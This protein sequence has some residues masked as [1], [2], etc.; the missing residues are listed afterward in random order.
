MKLLIKTNRYFVGVSLLV[1]CV[2]GV[3]FYLLFQIIIDRDINNK[4]QNR[5]NYVAKQLNISDSLLFY[6]KYSANTLSIRPTNGLLTREE[7][8]DTVLYDEVEKKS[9]GYRQLTF[10]DNINGQNYKIHLRRALVETHELI[11]GVVLL[12]GILFLALVAILALLNSLVSKQLWSPFYVTLEK[13][14]TYKADSGI[15]LQ[16]SRTS[17]TEFNE[18]SEAIEKM[19]RK[20][21]SEFNS[22]KEFTENASHEIQTP[23]A[24]IKSKMELLLQSPGLSEDQM[25][26]ISSAS[27]ATNRLSKL[28]EALI[29]LS[30]IENR[31][32]H[33]VENICVNDLVERHLANFEDLVN[34]KKISVRKLY[35]DILSIKMNP[36]LA[37]ILFENLIVNAIKHNC[38]PGFLGITID[39]NKIQISNTG[40]DLM[41]EPEKLFNRFVKGNHKSHSLGLGLPIVK[42]ICD[43]YLLPIVYKIEN[44]IHEIDVR[45]PGGQ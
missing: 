44:R 25:Q 15:S 24:I 38:S 43:T 7:I 18:L 22:Q 45:F 42:A 5:R 6:Q 32:F 3:L 19:S 39:L 23:L 35:H 9:I 36:F 12:E 41:Q 27:A 37:D 40:E 14:S 10:G 17:V 28:N 21:S 13:I 20:I 2:G 26:L 1:F 30:R 16:F 33:V 34:M 31:Q 4:L 29:I 11:K 8:S